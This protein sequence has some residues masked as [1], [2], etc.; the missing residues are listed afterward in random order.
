L[1]GR[2][3][4]VSDTR[5]QTVL[6]ALPPGQPA[7]W[8]HIQ[9]ILTW[10]HRPAAV[11]YTVFPVR[12]RRLIGWVTRWTARH[13]LDPLRHHGAVTT[14]AGGR[15]SRLDLPALANAARAQAAARW[16]TWH[17]HIA[18]TT[19][20]AKPWEQYQAEHQRDPSKLP[21]AEARRRFEAQPRVL[22]MLA[23][24]AY[25]AV[26][27]TLDVDDLAALQAG[28]AVYVALH[29]QHALTGDALITPDG[30]LLQPATGSLADRLRYHAAAAR[31]L[32][33]LS[34]SQQLV[35]VRAAPVPDE[36]TPAP[37]TPASAAPAAATPVARG[38]G[39]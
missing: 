9:Q 11:P 8:L 31:V 5:T 23:H 24:N 4:P 6:L 3:L 13:L 35:A 27:H 1:E 33:A 21:L 20:G 15:L 29:W 39:G 12:R 36:P 10:Q 16:W 26:P 18:R 30:H 28:E 2:T 7:S 25:P 22:A 38:T 34:G 37:A 19:P 17:A 14:A 32:A